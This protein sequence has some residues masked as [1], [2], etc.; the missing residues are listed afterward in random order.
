MD[1]FPSL[2]LTEWFEKNK[3][4]L[5]W[6]KDATAYGIWISE[7]MLQQTQ[8]KTVVPYYLKWMD[9]FPTLNDLAKAPL[10]E[11]IKLW[12]GLGY[13]S[14]ARNLHEGAKYI[15]KHFNGE[16]PDTKEA[17]LTIKGIGPYTSG[18]L[19]S[20]AFKK[21]ATLIDGNVKR[22]ASRFWGLKMDFAQK[23]E[24]ALLESFLE[25]AL[26][27]S[28]E[29]IFNEAMMELGAMICTPKNPDCSQCPLK[30]H[31]HANLHQSQ[32]DFP[33]KILRKKSIRLKRALF[34]FEHKGAFLVE[35]RTQG[36]MKDLY[37]FPYFEFKNKKEA[38]LKLLD[39]KNKSYHVKNLPSITHTFTHHHVT[40]F[41]Y[42][43][44]LKERF[45]PG[46]WLPIDQM[47]QKPFS[48]G[49]RKAY[50]YF[51]DVFC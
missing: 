12:E 41:P 38:D 1:P 48:A 35:K 31:C 49:H 3:R 30:N 10:D 36:V 50:A 44:Q 39:Y 14:R 17:L 45:S 20:F 15:A 19:L 43:I 9:A 33:I 24:Y 37:E 6:R 13:Y 32:M 16:I 22:V 28:L 46:L 21:R 47:D 2:K 40:L 4:D 23:K 26:P 29:W 51:K 25:K 11:V 18:A 42:Y 27:L 7:V 5:P 8:V 34:I